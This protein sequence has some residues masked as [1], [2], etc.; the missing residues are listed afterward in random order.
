VDSDFDLPARSDFDVGMTDE[1]TRGMNTLA[2]KLEVGLRYAVSDIDQASV[3][4]ARLL[5][6]NVRESDHRAG[7]R[8]GI[9]IRR[10]PRY[11]GCKSKSTERRICRICS[12]LSFLRLRS[13]SMSSTR[14]VLLLGEAPQ[15]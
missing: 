5:E 13:R 1:S 2:D 9:N 6:D 4:T 11:R 12:A 8:V 14:Y 10:N 15:S 3:F 7:T